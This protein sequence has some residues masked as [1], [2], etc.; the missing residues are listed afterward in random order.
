[1]KKKSSLKIIHIITGLE[2]GGAQ[3]MLLKV[4][5][6]MDRE[7]FDCQVLS[8]VPYN[9]KDRIPKKL[10]QLGI[11][12][13]T[14][15][16]TKSSKDFKALLRLMKIVFVEKPDIVQSWMYHSN[17]ITSFLKPIPPFPK[18]IWNI[19]SDTYAFPGATKFDYIIGRMLKYISYIIPSS[20]IYVSNSSYKNYIEKYG[21]CA[22]SA[23][24][25]QNGFDLKKF[26]PLGDGKDSV[27]EELGISSNSKLILFPARF[28]PVKDFPLFFKAA[29]IF[30]EKFP[31]THF[32]MVGTAVNP[33]NIE[34]KLMIPNNKENHFHFLGIRD[35]MDKIYNSSDIVTITSKFEGFP[36]VIGEAMACGRPC[37]ST[38]VG[39]CKEIIGNT[40]ITV[41]YGYPELIANGWIE[42]FSLSQFDRI[43]L[44]QK[45]TKRIYNKYSIEASVEKYELLYNSLGITANSKKIS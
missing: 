29:T 16:F 32:I 2:D 9:D 18:L 4:L 43:E 38:D 12:T 34:L 36:N 14:L 7:K 11:K 24:V 8:L 45:A 13:E 37:V 39:E 28:S 15:N 10:K 44:G 20:T 22:N 19:R 23:K 40:G 41:K 6:S 3:S 27:R 21:Y 42:L 26:K 25:I 31:D 35:D 17:F 1:M 5:S 33:D 30:L